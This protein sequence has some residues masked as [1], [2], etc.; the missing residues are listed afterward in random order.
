M[1]DQN[2]QQKKLQ[3]FA[4]KRLEIIVERPVLSRLLNALDD[5]AVTG[6]TV[7]PAMAGR[8]QSGSWRRD[9]MVGTA[10]EMVMVICVTDESRVEHVLSV[11]YDL[12]SHHIGIVTIDDVSVIRADHF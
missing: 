3:T 10:G 1:D 5:Q 8:G 4:K 12:I 7:I 6:Y 9:G 2:E 11:V